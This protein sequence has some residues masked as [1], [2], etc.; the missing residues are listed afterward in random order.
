[1]H[2]L[3]WIIDRLASCRPFVTMHLA[4]NYKRFPDLV[5]RLFFIELFLEK[6]KHRIN[7]QHALTGLK[8]PFT[9]SVNVN[10]FVCVS[11]NV[12][13]FVNF[14]IVFAMMLTL[15]QRMCISNPFFASV[16]LSLLLLFLKM[17]TQTLTSSVN[18]LLFPVIPWD[19]T[20]QYYV[21]WFYNEI[22]ALFTL[23]GKGTGTST[24]IKWKVS[25]HVEMFTLVQDRD[26]DRDLLFSILPVLFP[27]PVPISF[28]FTVNKPSN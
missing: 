25:Y 27:V 13:I 18:G 4:D 22:H 1:M 15:M 7:L 17:Q 8:N 21:V 3:S 2:N 5:Y 26:R 28:P 24:G 20:N 14:N 9:V 6:E 10:I 16:S 23:H 12:N 19:L 11:I